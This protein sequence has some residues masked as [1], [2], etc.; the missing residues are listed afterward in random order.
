MPPPDRYNFASPDA[1]TLIIVK[2]FP[3]PGWVS[4]ESLILPEL[5]QRTA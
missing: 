4:G 5:I 1:G 2:G 3:P